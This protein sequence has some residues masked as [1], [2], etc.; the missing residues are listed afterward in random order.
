MTFAFGF[1]HSVE[2][3]PG[4]D[5]LGKDCRISPSVSV[6]RIGKSIPER[7]IS[8]GD[9]VILLDNVRL[10]LGDITL[11]P[12]ARLVLGNQ[13]IIN[14]GS[15][16]SGEGGLVIDEEVL[17]GA[18]VRILSAGHEIHRGVSSIARNP[19]TCG[20]IHIGRG[21]WIGAGSTILQGV[22]IGEGSVVGAGS[23]V[24]KDVPPYAVAVGNPA[25]IKHYRRGYKPKK[26][27]AFWR[28]ST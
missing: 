2:H 15:Y 27:W 8:L 16:I 28:K 18:H 7:G 4:I 24:T 10:V 3:F 25:R 5:K 19:I 9:K 14:V 17:I 12:E 6:M 26:L 11:L 22:I 13:V 21:A 20:A 1:P 23:V